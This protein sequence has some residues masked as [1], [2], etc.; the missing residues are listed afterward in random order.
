MSHGAQPV[1]VD[2]AAILL[3]CEK[4]GALPG[5][6]PCKNWS[7]PQARSIIDLIASH[8]GQTEDCDIYLLREVKTAFKGLGISKIGTREQACSLI[9]KYLWPKPPPKSEQKAAISKQFLKLVQN[10][11]LIDAK[12]LLTAHPSVA[13]ARSTSKGYTAMHYAAMAGA[14]PMLDF[15]TD[16]DIPPDVLSSPAD[17]SGAVTPAEVAAEYK[18]EPAVAHLKRL[19][20]GIAFLR[21]A[22]ASDDEGRLRAA[23]RAGIGPAVAILLRRNPHLARVSAVAP[24]GALLA[25]VSS[26]HIDVLLELARY[27]ALEVERDGPSALEVAVATAQVEVAN[28]L[29]DYERAAVALQLGSW[30]TLPDSLRPRERGGRRPL[31][32]AMVRA[33]L[34]SLPRTNLSHPYT[35]QPV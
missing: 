13:H 26:G 4:L 3:L 11:S 7:V 22:P 29:H 20:E 1:P 34:P 15:L 19:K 24:T 16:Q 5:G 10:G 12:A 33:A 25:A 30:T 32:N 2:D 18:R 21:A 31:I 9:Q 6:G 23:A 28:L 17:G 27:G 14:I 35:H 8:K